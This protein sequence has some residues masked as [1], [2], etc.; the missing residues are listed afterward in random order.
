MLNSLLRKLPDFLGGIQVRIFFYS[1]HIKHKE[2]VI[3]ENVTIDG[4]DNIVIGKK[5]RVCPDV[6]IISENSGKIFI[7]ENFF[8]NYNSFIYADQSYIK[9]GDD[10]LLGPD[11]LIINT[12]HAV[13][14]NELIRKQANKSQPIDIGNDV[15]IGAKSTILAGVSIGDGAV[16][17][18]G[19]VVNKNVEANA[20][21]GG[22]PAKLIKYREV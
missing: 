6:K 18:A 21:V 16:V 9:I 8:A 15:W 1:K 20:I 22:V 14:K 5:F 19:S 7:G 13:Q 11:V 4:F 2:F 3:P 17:A 10:C 12:N